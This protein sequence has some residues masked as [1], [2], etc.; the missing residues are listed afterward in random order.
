LRT[1][2]FCCPVY[3]AES[4]VTNIDLFGKHSH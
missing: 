2:E 3:F 4:T 1:G